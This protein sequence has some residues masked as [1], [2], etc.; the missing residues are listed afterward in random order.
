VFF[1]LL[2]L[3]FSGVTPASAGFIDSVK[4][5][6]I[7]SDPPIVINQDNSQ[8][9]TLLHGTQNSSSYQGIGGGDIFVEDNALSAT[10]GSVGATSGDDSENNLYRDSRISI[11]VVRAGDSLAGIARMYDVSANTIAWANDIP[12][13]GTIKTGQT[14]VI[15]PVNGIQYTVKKGDTLA[16]IAKRY[17]AEAADISSFN[18]FGSN[19]TLVP[20]EI[21]IIPGGVETSPVNQTIARPRVVPG[22]GGPNLGTY[23]IWPVDGGTITQN[24]HGNNGVDIGAPR[25]TKVYASA[26]GKVIISRDGWNGG[27][28]LMIVIE[29]PNGTQTL[30]SHLSASFVSTGDTVVTGQVIGAVGSTGR[31]TG[32]HLH[33]EVH[34]ASNPFAK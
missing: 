14:L 21:I 20:G 6:F 27:Y 16:T 2:S 32:S 7:K 11:Y 12:A 10:L 19:T 1:G 4:G 18:D 30:Y 13:G 9:L 23:F 31:S 34:G 5:I 29:H 17:K 28:G 8:R 25:G 22:S 24:L 15:L 33:F 3:Y 26:P